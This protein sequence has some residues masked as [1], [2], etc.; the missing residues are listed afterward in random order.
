M[1]VLDHETHPSTIHN[2]MRYTA[3]QQ[4]VR[5]PNYPKLVTVFPVDGNPYQH[6]ALIPDTSST[7]CRYMDYETDAGCN[8]CKQPK[9]MEYIEKMK[10]LK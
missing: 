6:W 10:G 2:D 3:C 8:G 1:P 5:K 4:K 9:D 7:G